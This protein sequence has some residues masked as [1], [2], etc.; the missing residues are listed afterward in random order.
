MNLAQMHAVEG[1][2]AGV[3]SSLRIPVGLACDPD[4]RARKFLAI[5]LRPSSQ[6]LRGV[7]KLNRS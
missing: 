5:S 4:D 7:G 1:L 2:G 3:Y 6:S